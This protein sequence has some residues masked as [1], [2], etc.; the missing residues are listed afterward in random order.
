MT[1]IGSESKMWMMKR[2]T[3][4]VI[5][6]ASVACLIS[7][8]VLIF[9]PA[10]SLIP[11]LQRLRSPGANLFAVNALAFLGILGVLVTFGQKL[12]L[13][14]I[15]ARAVSLSS[16]SAGRIAGLLLFCALT[17]RL[18]FALAFPVSLQVSDDAC[19]H[20][21]A[22]DMAKD[23]G[24]VR[25]TLGADGQITR[26]PTAFWPV[27]YPAFLSLIYRLIGRSWRVGIAI[28]AVLS[29]ISVLLVWG[30]ATKIWGTATGRLAALA[31]CFYVPL[32]PNWLLAGPL[33]EML[34][35]L[36]VFIGVRAPVAFRYAALAGLVVL[37]ATFVKSNGLF[38]IALPF[39]AW[40][41]RT[42]RLGRSVALTLFAVVV[43]AVGPFLWGV[44]N[45]HALGHFVPL[46][47]NGGLTMVIG[48]NDEADGRETK[49]YCA[50]WHESS[51]IRLKELDEVRAD[52]YARQEAIRWI[53]Q[54][55]GRWTVLGFAKVGWMTFLNVWRPALSWYD[56][57][58]ASVWWNVVY[59]TVARFMFWLALCGF[60]LY[61]KDTVLS[62]GRIL[63]Y[64]EFLL[65]IPLL[66]YGYFALQAF[67]FYG[68]PRL[69]SY[70]EALMVAAAVAAM[71]SAR[72]VRISDS[73]TSAKGNGY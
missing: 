32:F 13:Q 34:I 59:K 40:W 17:L 38:L 53:R 4:L 71:I 3:R 47:T 23:H 69:R 50:A 44:R 26:T 58:P 51:R 67:V 14:W 6:I 63:R 46:S 18:T 72:R 27:G 9:Y 68:G 33:F 55:P 10:S 66:A 42:K 5:L 41:A 73:A 8:S 30:I 25:Q 70:I 65:L 45:L 60:L 36:A 49:Y 24:Y 28:N 22:A 1:S 56:G 62:I 12:L 64:R 39:F 43:V 20:E 61:A 37:A 21:R 15:S 29:S 16:M 52:R 57:K 54:N 19:Y 35:L 48:A 7:S 2:S 11:Q 31:L